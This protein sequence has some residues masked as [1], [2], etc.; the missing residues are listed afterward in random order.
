MWLESRPFQHFHCVTPVV[1]IHTSICLKLS[2]EFMLSCCEFHRLLDSISI[3][4]VSRED[5]AWFTSASAGDK[6]E[7]VV[8]DDS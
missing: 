1:N 4:E 3:S 2:R 7:L 6:F 8:E 5:G